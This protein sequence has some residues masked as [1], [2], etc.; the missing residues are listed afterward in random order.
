M[1]LLQK[2]IVDCSAPGGKTTVV[3]LSAGEQADYDAQQPIGA[4]E[5]AALNALAVRRVQHISALATL[6]PHLTASAATT[7]NDIT[8]VQAL[9]DQ[10]Q[11][12]QQPTGAQVLQVIRF[13][14]RTMAVLLS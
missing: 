3:P 11:A 12:G 8:A 5:M 6:T 2:I 7:T 9:I 13:L 1:G 4:A 10:I 14:L